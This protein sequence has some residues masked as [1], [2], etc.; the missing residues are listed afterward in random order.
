MPT[1]IPNLL[2]NGASGIAVGMATNM[3]THNLREVID[4]CVAYIDNNDIT[5]EE[6]MEF[7]KAPDFPTGAFIYGL[8]GVREAYL[9]GR[10]RVLIRARANIEDAGTHDKIIVTEIPYG[11]NKAE[12]IKSIAA[13]ANEKKI[14]GISNAN[15]ESDREGMRIVIDVKRDANAHSKPAGERCFGYCSG[16]GNQYANAQSA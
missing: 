7:V 5:I 3:P 16:Y 11:V 1:R 2:V 8:S 9:T 6:L 14:E 12:L 15:D 10:G 13:L 4:A